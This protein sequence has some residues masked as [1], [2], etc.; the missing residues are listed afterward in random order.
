VKADA[1]SDRPNPSG[2]VRCGDCGFGKSL[3][4]LNGARQTLIST[5]EYD[6]K[7]VTSGANL[8][9]FVSSYCLSNSLI[10]RLKQLASINRVAQRISHPRRVLDVCK[11]DCDNALWPLG[12][13]K[14]AV[15]DGA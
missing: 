13:L 4:D 5:L 3:L 2:A 6:E 8:E 11:Y 14:C 10:V 7:T 9:A 15:H 1:Y 12:E